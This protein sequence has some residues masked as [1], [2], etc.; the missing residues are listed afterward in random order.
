MFALLA[1]SGAFALAA[2]EDPRPVEDEFI[3]P[4]VEEPVAPAAED[5]AAPTDAVAPPPAPTDSSSQPTEPRTSEQSVQPESET[6]F[7]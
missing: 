3:G 1:V 2:C 6:L 7:Y 5:V 4:P